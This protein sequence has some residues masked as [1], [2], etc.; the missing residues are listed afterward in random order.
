[1][2]LKNI[3]FVF[4]SL[5]LVWSACKSQDGLSKKDAKSVE[6]ERIA[7]ETDTQLT[8]YDWNTGYLKA[9]RINKILLVDVYTEW[10]GWCKVMDRNTYKDASIIKQLNKDFVCVKFNPEIAKKDYVF[11]TATID[12]N[13]L[14]A[15]LFDRRSGGYPTTTFWINPSKKERLEVI[16]GYKDPTA[17]AAILNSLSAKKNQTAE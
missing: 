14:Q 17:F 1:M 13:L 8:F 15:F 10:C 9:K 7:H 11:D 12:N 2:K 5:S 6:N 3:L 4:L 16:P